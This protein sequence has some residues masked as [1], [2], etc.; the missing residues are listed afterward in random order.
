MFAVHQKARVR[1]S[2]SEIGNIAEV[3]EKREDKAN[4]MAYMVAYRND[5]REHIIACV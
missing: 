5:R 2:A 3:S 1:G 4:Y